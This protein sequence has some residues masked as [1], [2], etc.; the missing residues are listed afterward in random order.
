M[1]KVDATSLLRIDLKASETEIEAAYRKRRDE[2]RKR[3]EAARDRNTQ[4]RC[5]REYVALEQ[6]R[7]ILL[8]ETE[9]LIR[10]RE[11]PPV[12]RD[13]RSVEPEALPAER[14]EPP[15]EPEAVPLAC[16]A[17]TVEQE[18]SP[19]A[20][21]AAPA[22]REEQSVEPEA[23]PAERE[24]AP[25]ERV[26]PPVERVSSS[27]ERVSG[28]I[29]RVSS[30][31]EPVSGPIKY[32][33]S[34]IERVSP[35]KEPELTPVKIASAQVRTR[36]TQ[37][38]WLAIAGVMFIL[39]SA[40]VIVFFWPHSPDKFNPGKLVL[41]TVPDS[42][43]VW[44]DGVFQGKTPLVLE[45][46]APGDCRLKIGLSGYEAQ[47]LIV[48]VKPG[49]E[50]STRIIQLVPAEQ[51]SAA[52]TATQTATSQTDFTIVS[53]STTPDVLTSERP[54]AYP[55]ER[56]PQTHERLLPEAEIADLNYAELRYAINEIYARHGAPFLSEPEIE[57]QFRAFDWYHPSRDL[58][59]SQIEAS[60]SAIEKKNVEILAHLRDQKRPR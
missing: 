51:S 30:P 11:A 23:L 28:P 26:S 21:E 15:V 55:G 9:D 29:K 35:P 14:E 46:L 12:E 1:D 32:V 27:I 49:D 38:Q 37:K 2:V 19:L 25:A 58:K 34:S 42:A 56:Y 60:F 10:E 16:E 13:E 41:N 7:N 24:A 53:G 4:T 47:Q 43:D 8:A 33:S 54:S 57:K 50:G 3:F 39:V 5:E 18:A 48:S 44:L 22:E 59:L 36:F 20:R 31:I 6:A 17:L 40:S 45:N 52:S